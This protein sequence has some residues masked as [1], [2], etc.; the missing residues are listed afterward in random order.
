MKTNQLCTARVGVCTTI[1]ALQAFFASNALAAGMP[2]DACA[3]LKPAD[4]QVLAPT[5]K[6]D[7]GKPGS[8]MAPLGVGCVYNWG[9]R[10]SE[11]GEPGVT[12]LVLDTSKAYPGVDTA[13]LKSGFAAKV[14][15]TNA[16]K[17]LGNQ[18]WSLPG[19]GDAADFVY[20]S[21]P[22]NGTAESYVSKQGV[23]VSVMFHGDSLANKDKVIAL[24]KT[25]VARL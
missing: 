2:K 3:L 6:I 19:I 16:N 22:H 12:I 15:A 1:A 10:T 24:L 23:V 17:A 7:D 13:T 18:A 9:P 25:A 4:I 5:A 21:R 20:E 14:E 8:D 11:W